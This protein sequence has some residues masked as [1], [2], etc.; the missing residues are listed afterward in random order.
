MK[1]LF[2]LLVILAAGSLAWR[3]GGREKLD[4]LSK[5]DVGGRAKSRVD[6]VLKGMR[7]EGGTLGIR[8]QTAVCEWDRGAVV[9]SDQNELE[10]ALDRF[11]RWCSEKKLG[12]RKISGYDVLD[13]SC[14]ASGDPCFVN[15]RIEGA[16]YKLK[17]PAGTRISWAP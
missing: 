11:N 15:V 10:L 5:G 1:A 6:T 4:R 13:A 9:I 12:N 16:P 8:F 17:V 2:I 14:E 7:D 3:F